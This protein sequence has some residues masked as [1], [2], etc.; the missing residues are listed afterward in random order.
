MTCRDEAKGKAGLERAVAYILVGRQQSTKPISQDHEQKEEIPQEHA[1][2][3]QAQR[4]LTGPLGD[5]AR[6]SAPEVFHPRNRPGPFPQASA[7]LGRNAGLPHPG[8]Y[9]AP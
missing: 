6:Q 7:P 1:I 2:E 8:S 4:F 5:Y 9:D 3:R